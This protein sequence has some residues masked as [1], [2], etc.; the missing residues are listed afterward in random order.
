[1][2]ESSEFVLSKADNPESMRDLSGW[3]RPVHDYVGLDEFFSTQSLADG[4]HAISYCG[5]F[6]ELNL[7]RRPSKAMVVFF[8]AALASRTPEVKLPVFSG[9]K[10]LETTDA[11]ILMVSDPGLY[12]D[13]E[14]RLAWY[15]GAKGMQ[16][17]ADLAKVLQHVQHVLA[18]ERIVLYGASGGG[19][20]ALFYAP[21]LNNAIAMPCN[22]QISLLSYSS[23]ILSRFLKVAYGYKGAPSAFEN[24]EILDKPIV[25]IPADHTRGIRVLYLQNALDERHF[26]RDFLPF[27]Q[28]YGFTRGKGLM[29]VHSERLISVCGENWGEGHRAPSA[30]FVY[31]L[32]HS[33]TGKDGWER[34]PEIIPELYARTANRFRQVALRFDEA[35]FHAQAWLHDQ[36]TIDSITLKLYRGS[37]E[38]ETIHVAN[39]ELGRF[40]C[41]PL[42]GHYCVAARMAR[43]ASVENKSW[44]KRLLDMIRSKPVFDEMKSRVV[45]VA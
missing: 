40:S 4:I 23:G 37:V 9:A 17:Q 3:N 34:L 32:L 5:V 22:P 19:F 38:V 25:R 44:G 10:A 13:K 42:K 2:Y 18:I 27:L 21:F 39:G 33:L 26:K 14:I 45:V 31:A 36:S 7:H 12:L 8:N 11:C 43:N 28:G 24:A 35:G 1:M 41:A 15:A 6:L 16:L 29:E 20:A 30:E